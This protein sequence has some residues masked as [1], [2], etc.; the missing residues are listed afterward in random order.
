MFRRPALHL[1][2]TVAATL[3]LAGGSHA[4]SAAPPL[5]A[6]TPGQCEAGVEFD[7]APRFFCDLI[8]FEKPAN[9]QLEPSNTMLL[10]AP[11]QPGSASSFSVTT[12]KREYASFAAF[13][14]AEVPIAKR[15]V[16]PGST[17]VFVDQATLPAGNAFTVTVHLP[18]GPVH[19][20]VGVL[21]KRTPYLI[22]T[23]ATTDADQLA[24]QQLIE[25]ADFEHPPG[26][27]PHLLVS[28]QWKIELQST[29]GLGPV[30]VTATNLEI[31]SRHWSTQLTVSNLGPAPVA[32][33]GIALLRYESRHYANA[34][35]FTSTSAALQLVPAPRA[36]AGA[37][38]T[39]ALAAGKSWTGSA[40]GPENVAFPD[41]YLRVAVSFASP[42]G[43][44]DPLV[45]Q[46]FGPV[47]AAPAAA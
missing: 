45:F 6:D 35:G 20:I 21:Y 3:S 4:A 10:A 31:G 43:D 28:M 33:A 30:S 12:G 13:A 17:T 5:N 22:S 14:A 27:A 1:V 16:D 23:V 36:P 44:P 11:S 38:G 46:A 40:G 18:S 26:V 39:I 9:W 24:L 2:A 15:L 37:R 34:L 32:V 7:G 42:G 19:E 8:S 47:L 41:P 29:S 25:S